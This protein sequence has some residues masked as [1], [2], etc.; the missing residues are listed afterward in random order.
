MNINVNSD[1]DDEDPMVFL[2]KITNKT[3]RRGRFSPREMAQLRHLATEISRLD[4]ERRLSTIGVAVILLHVAI[5]CRSQK[6]SV[7]HVLG[8]NRYR[9]IPIITLILSHKILETIRFSRVLQQQV[10]LIVQD[11]RSQYKQDNL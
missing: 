9:K 3:W 2:S 7:A 5:I 6:V 8:S 4:H 1:K 10:D 11:R